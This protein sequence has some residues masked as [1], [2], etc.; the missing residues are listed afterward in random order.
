MGAPARGGQSDRCAGNLKRVDRRL[1]WNSVKL[2]DDVTQEVAAPGTLVQVPM[3][4]EPLNKKLSDEVAQPSDDPHFRRL[5]DVL[6]NHV[7]LYRGQKPLWIEDN[8]RR[9]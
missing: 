2:A 5:V 4:I 7:L 8:F 1:N 3:P 9:A 6:I